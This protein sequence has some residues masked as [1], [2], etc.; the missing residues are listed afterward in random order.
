MGFCNF[1]SLLG[2]LRFR[3]QNHYEW[4]TTPSVLFVHKS[5][6]IKLA[7]YTEI[8]STHLAWWRNGSLSL[9][10]RDYLKPNIYL[11]VVRVCAYNPN[12]CLIDVR[13]CTE[14][15]DDGSMD[16]RL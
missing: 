16:V 2:N 14:N 9:K 6:A 8:Y 10:V 15:P 13:I 7:D 3:C 1:I 11:T 4:E 5:A 12:I